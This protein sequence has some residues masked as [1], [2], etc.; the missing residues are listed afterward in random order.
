MRIFLIAPVAAV[1][2]LAPAV[3]AAPPGVKECLAAT[4]AAVQLR[5]AHKL[6]E[7]RAQLLVCAADSCPSDV[8]ADCTH[9]VEELN[10]ALPTV[11]FTVRSPAGDEL[12]AVQVTMDGSV[13][14]DHLDGSALT[15][16]PGA[17]ELTFTTAGQAPVT[18]SLILH[19]AEKD[20]RETVV[21]GTTPAVVPVSP[22]APAPAPAPPAPSSWSTLRITGLAVGGAGVVGLALGGVFGGLAA[23]DWSS[24]KNTCP[25]FKG[26]SATEVSNAS[27]AATLGTGSTVAFIAGGVLAAGGVMLFILAPKSGTSQVGLDAGP[28][29]LALKG[30]F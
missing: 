30:W 13:V 11:V 22:A 16:D 17:H 23:S 26:C 3:H 21:V 6:R 1:L 5:T 7:A 10:A 29:S 15:L 2:S 14:A 4:E 9:G 8:H 27:S 24:V 18:R 19:E 25:T 20:R 28:R 12:S